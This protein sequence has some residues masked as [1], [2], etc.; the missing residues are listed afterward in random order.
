M[1]R[2]FPTAV[3][4]LAVPAIALMV[5]A[6]E[7]SPPEIG[8]P[9]GVSFLERDSAGVVVA[10]TLGSRARSP[11]GWVVDTVP[12]YQ[13]GESDGDEPYLFTTIAGARQLADG[14]VVV[15]DRPTCEWRFFGADGVFLERTGGTGMGPGEFHGGGYA[16]CVLVPSQHPDSLFGWDGDRL[17]VFDD[18]GRFSRRQLL[19]WPSY[20]VNVVEGVADGVAAVM[21]TVLLIP[22]VGDLS[23]PPRPVHYAMLELE[24]GRVAWERTGLQRERVYTVDRSG[25]LSVARMPFDIPPSVAMARDGL[26][27]T[28]GENHGPEILQY[29]TGGHLSRIIRLAEP[30]AAP[31]TRQE[32]HRLIELYGELTLPEIKPVFS[33]LLVDDEGWL[34]AELYRSTR[35]APVRWLVFDP[36]GE[37]FGSVDLPPDLDVRQIGRDFVLGVW[38]DEIGVNYVRRHALSGRA[39]GR[40][41][42]IGSGP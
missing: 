42:T 28:L 13:V 23:H 5:A 37:G 25:I 2:M 29:G 1:A 26:Y 32:I 14:R 31:P 4:A 17:S 18:R 15:L 3:R 27:M 38:R 20:A 24:T 39:T 12:E 11:S 40:H 22:E 6:C 36:N 7:S 16:W 21:A 35:L 34:W 8:L 10:T 41:D 9:G 19:P 30:P 33:R